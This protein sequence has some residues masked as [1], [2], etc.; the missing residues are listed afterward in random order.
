AQPMGYYSPATIVGDAQRHGLEIRP[1]D[2]NESSWD[3]TLEPT[4]DGFQFAV[5]MGLRWVKGTQIAD[6][7]RI[8]TARRERAFASIEDFV[9]R[10]H[11]PARMHAALAEAGALGAL[12]PARRDALWQVA[13]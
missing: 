3:C 9:R 5:R 1:I 13:G 7:E 8:V 11:V 6:G 10:A 4:S 2:V 12:A